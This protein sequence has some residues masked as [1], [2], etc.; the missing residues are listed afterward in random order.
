MA[1]CPIKL[2]RVSKTTVQQTRTRGDAQHGDVDLATRVK[3]H[4]TQSEKYHNEDLPG[5]PLSLKLFRDHMLPR[6]YL[7][8]STLD[9]PWDIH[10][11]DHVSF[12]QQL[13]TKYVKVEHELALRNEPVFALVSMTFNSKEC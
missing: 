13:W 10:H 11:P 3:G 7:Y 9:D 8:V 6:W 1:A 2:T 5:Y 12:A 4:R